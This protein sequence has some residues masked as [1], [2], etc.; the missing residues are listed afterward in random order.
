MNKMQKTNFIDYRQIF[1]NINGNSDPP[2]IPTLAV[3]R[4]ASDY[5]SYS[6]DDLEGGKQ[7]NPD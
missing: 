5:L 3:S 1:L 7:H 6:T 2:I 4:A